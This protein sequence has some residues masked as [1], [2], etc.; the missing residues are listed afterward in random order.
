MDMTTSISARLH[1]HVDLISECR[2]VSFFQQKSA[3]DRTGQRPLTGPS[4]Q[5]RIALSSQMSRMTNCDSTLS[6]SKLRCMVQRSNS[7]ISPKQASSLPSWYTR[8]HQSIL[9][10]KCTT[11]KYTSPN[12]QASLWAWFID[13]SSSKYLRHETH[14]TRIPRLRNFSVS[15]YIHRVQWLP[16]HHLVGY[17]YS[18][19]GALYLTHSS[20]SG[21]PYV[22]SSSSSVTSHSLFFR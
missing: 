20:P 6:L 16:V 12:P 5:V 13:D 7:G 18:L 2:L 3:S 11:Q 17:V 9:S 22:S 21:R 8:H 19:Y 4:N 10:I 1:N 14:F 15:S